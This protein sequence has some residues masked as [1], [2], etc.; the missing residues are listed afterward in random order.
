M[1]TTSPAAV[2]VAVQLTGSL[3]A[4]GI[5]GVSVSGPHLQRDVTQLTISAVDDPRLGVRELTPQRSLAVTRCAA[6]R[7]RL[8][9]GRAAVDAFGAFAARLGSRS[10]IVE[11]LEAVLAVEG[12]TGAVVQLAS[13]RDL[14]AA[15]E[16]LNVGG[17]SALWSS[18]FAPVQAS[19][20]RLGVSNAAPFAHVSDEMRQAAR[21]GFTA[22]LRSR[23]LRTGPVTIPAGPP[24]DS[25]R[26]GCRL[27]GVE[28]SD[29]WRRLQRRRARSAVGPHPSRLRATSAG[30]AAT[31]STMS[32]ASVRP[33]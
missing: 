16:H 7:G 27:R 17:A 25:A 29:V 8:E 6:C 12:V 2:P 9:R 18:R 5:C 4:C 14:S 1:S 30:A 3:L 24:A 11:R 31:C 10:L 28:R 32:V 19:D 22:L 23:L 13:P 20:A 33:R 15:L 26:R 21:D